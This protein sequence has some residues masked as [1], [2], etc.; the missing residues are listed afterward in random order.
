MGCAREEHHA[1]WGRAAF[2]MEP[3]LDALVHA[4]KYGGRP[5]LAR[6]LG[7]LLA[8]RIPAAADL[9]TAVPLHRTR[10]R[11]RGYNQAGLLAREA[12]RTWGAP[13]IDGLL[14]RVRG[15]RAQARL[16]RPGRTANVEGAFGCRAASWVAGRR[17]VLVDD[18]ATSG[19][20]LL[21]AAGPLR[22][23]GAERVLAVTLALA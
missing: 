20:T 4:L 17:I 10:R 9:V 21:A 8:R 16:P 7:R 3:P 1:F 12:S 19:S 11:D 23:A 6:P 5:D 18:V 14:V 22:E 13:P 2:W 15:T